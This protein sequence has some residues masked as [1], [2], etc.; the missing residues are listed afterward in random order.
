[1]LLCLTYCHQCDGD[2][3]AN[4]RTDDFT[5]DGLNE[6]SYDDISV[7]GR[8]CRPLLGNQYHERSQVWSSR[9]SRV[10]SVGCKTPDC[11][12]LQTCLLKVSVVLN[13]NSSR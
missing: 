2:S 1:M 13:H 5:D 12:N 11:F 6:G 8:E 10:L 9:S 7:R 3:S 4:K